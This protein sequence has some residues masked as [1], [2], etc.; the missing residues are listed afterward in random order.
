ML[1]FYVIGM[2]MDQSIR[3]YDTKQTIFIIL[4]VAFIACLIKG[5]FGV[6]A[7]SFYYNNGV[8]VAMSIICAILELLVIF[9]LV[10]CMNNSKDVATQRNAFFYGEEDEDGEM[11]QPEPEPVVETHNDEDIWEDS[12]Y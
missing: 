3:Y 1:A 2:L 5:F 4:I 7:P 9:A 6:P 8:K 12:K 10:L 11:P